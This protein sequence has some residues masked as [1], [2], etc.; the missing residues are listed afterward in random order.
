M[1]YTETTTRSY[2][3]R[4]KDAIKG[5]FIG[6]LAFVIG[7]LLLFW[8]EGNF[9]KTRQD[10]GEARE[11]AISVEDVSSVD[12]ALN[13][14]LIH[15][16]AFADTKDVLN[17]DIFG[18]STTAIRLARKVEYYQWSEESHK[19]KRDKLGGGEET[20]TTYTYNKV[21]KDDPISSDDFKDPAYQD[22]N[23]ILTSVPNAE[24]TAE[25]VT[26]GAYRLPESMADKIQGSVPAEANP[27]PAQLK[28]LED[29]IKSGLNEAPKKGQ[30]LI[31]V[32]GNVIY[33]GFSPNS[34]QV[35]DVRITLTKVLP[36]DISIIAKVNGS[37]FEPYVT[38]NGRTFD[39]VDMGTHSAA[40]ML[41]DADT[42]NE[43]LTW[44][45]RL[46]GTVLIIIGLKALFGLLGALFKVIPFMGSL[47][48]A[49][50]GLVC[51]LGGLI[52]SLLIIAIAW[53]Y[54]RPLIGIALL[55]LVIGGIWYLRKAS[56]AKAA[57]ASAQS[58]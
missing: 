12:A 21:W 45:L 30:Q 7:T 2:W 28:Q 29:E 17:D 43:V 27:S 1:A 44:I 20:T 25:T 57:A 58:A 33:L 6:F 26:F 51:I 24:Q 16:S 50:V 32:S 39:R 37:T 19:K 8:N 54:Y 31:H 42:E 48:D 10:I 9:V 34:P 22:S 47:V 46:V 13:G 52:W 53:L 3:Q 15:A 56:K 41:A 14:K 23:F 55:A 5:I 4:L 11:A 18:V 49:G 35:G 36:A 40:Q 38:R